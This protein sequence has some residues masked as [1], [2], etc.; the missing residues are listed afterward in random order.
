MEHKAVLTNGKLRKTSQKGMKKVQPCWP[1]SIKCKLNENSLP[2]QSE[3]NADKSKKLGFFHDAL[4]HILK[5]CKVFPLPVFFLVACV[6]Q[7][8]T[9]G[10]KNRKF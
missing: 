2:Y 5:K 7:S 9:R 1:K 4:H 10:W 3:K 8:L 6:M